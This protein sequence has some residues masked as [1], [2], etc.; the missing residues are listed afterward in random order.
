LHILL[1][2]REKGMGG[3]ITTEYVKAQQSREVLS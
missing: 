3:I 1:I 2:D